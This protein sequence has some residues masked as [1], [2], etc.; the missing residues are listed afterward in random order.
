MDQI[1]VGFVASLLANGASSLLGNILFGSREKPPTAS[2]LA[3]EIQQRI[4]LATLLQRAT[5]AVAKL[6][7]PSGSLPDS[8]K[9]FLTS[10]DLDAI[11]R[12]IYAD[13]LIYADQHTSVADIRKEFAVSLQLY[14][15]ETKMT[16]EFGDELFNLIVAGCEDTLQACIQ[17]NILSAHEAKSAARHILVLDQLA[18]LRKHVVLLSTPLKA[19]LGD[20]LAFEEK[21]R[22]Q[23][24]TRH[25]FIVPPH[26]DAARRIPIDR[27]YV[28]PNFAAKTST[29]EPDRQLTLDMPQLLRTAYRAVVLGN[30]GS[31]KST[32]ACK[33]CHD[34]AEHYADRLYSWRQLTPVL[35]VLREYGAEKKERRCSILEALESVAKSRYQ[36]H[37][38]TGAFDY[39]LSSGRTLVIFDGLDELL[40]TNF[41][42]EVTNDIELF[43]QLY[44][45][46]PVLVTSRVVGYE[47]A[48][49]DTARFETFTIAPFGDAQ[50]DEYV[51]K[52]FETDVDLTRKQQQEHALAFPR[53]SKSVPDL[54]ANPL[55][56][57]LMCNIYRGENYIPRNRP[58]LYEKCAT[59]L[60]ERWD[61]SRGIW[62]PLPFEAHIK[63]TIMFLAEWIYTGEKLQSGITED[64]LVDKTREYLSKRR[65]EDSHE[66]DKAARE[67]IQFCRGRAWVFTDVG[68]TR[69][70]ESIYQFT[71]RTFLEYFASAHL[72]RLNPT[73]EALTKLL[74]PRIAKREWDMVTQLALQIQSRNVEGAAD[75]LLTKILSEAERARSKERFALLSFAARCL[76]FM[77]PSPKTV[78]AITNAVLQHGL[79]IAS[80]NMR[81]VDKMPKARDAEPWTKD[82]AAILI[83]SLTVTTTENASPLIDASRELLTEFITTNAEHKG[84]VAVETVETGLF[85]F[86]QRESHGPSLAFHSL[87]T[88]ASR[89][90]FDSC[91]APIRRLGKENWLVCLL[92]VWRGLITVKEAFQWHDP[93]A[94]F[95]PSRSYVNPPM[96]YSELSSSMLRN[97]VRLIEGRLSP[98]DT[99]RILAEMRDLEETLFTMPP[100]WIEV[101]E[102][103]RGHPHFFALIL[104]NMKSSGQRVDEN[105]SICSLA[106]ENVPLVAFVTAVLLR[107]YAAMARPGTKD[108]ELTEFARLV[109]GEP[110][111]T[112]IHAPSDKVSRKEIE[113]SLATFS[114][115]DRQR[116]FLETWNPD[117]YIRLVDSEARRDQS[118]LSKL[119][120]RG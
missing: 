65:F 110:L 75:E 83:S 72:V 53:E 89:T 22:A 118:W 32:L 37:P 3:S 12:Q 79:E 78:R 63:P 43:C 19:G 33:I 28:M 95:R 34:L 119:K 58:D 41:R 104:R 68:T 9:R 10:P 101:D 27:L 91:S 102:R 107:V 35:L 115:A 92:G 23:V 48:P 112:L 52:W 14:A 120:M 5:T 36:V 61:R 44:P 47:Q 82:E 6:N 90:V 84:V 93:T 29:Q 117:V 38:P 87:W 103:G 67:F 97:V 2:D 94:F 96:T 86:V 111:R 113:A 71:H 108:E 25:G 51:R 20:I 40:D 45:A 70:G 76:E 80:R 4:P 50:T 31:G 16:P 55:M 116:D 11:V 15:T 60:F 39:L 100:P 64:Q 69:T 13:R 85:E 24:S 7:H 49:L 106:P 114:L 105:R 99:E 59:M 77:V 17:D 18:M 88:E 46:V 26:F 21:L 98:K 62:K 1:L 30:P 54:R 73:P 57:S 42:Q 56:L 109:G 81:A 66:A 74:V 8:I